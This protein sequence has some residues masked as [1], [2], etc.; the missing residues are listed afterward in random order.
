MTNPKGRTLPLPFSTV[1]MKNTGFAFRYSYAV[2]ITSPLKLS[3]DLF[4]FSGFRIALG[5]SGMTGNE[6]GF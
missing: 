1:A 3:W 2:L 6:L 5:A 4:N